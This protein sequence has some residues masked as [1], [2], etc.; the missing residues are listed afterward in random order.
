MTDS[1]AVCLS[2]GH[3]IVTTEVDILL[4]G[5]WILSD[6]ARIVS[7]HGGT[8]ENITPRSEVIREML[9]RYPP[10][11]EAGCLEMAITDSTA[12]CRES[13][14]N[15]PRRVSASS[16]HSVGDA[17]PLIVTG[18]GTYRRDW[19]EPECRACLI[20]WSVFAF[21]AVAIV[22]MAIMGW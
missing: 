18:Q 17:A 11:I 20:I 5:V 3:R 13:G 8:I 1:K 4:G 12:G 21:L 2:N 6:G 9:D 22:V 7:M 16:Y 10:E 19:A 15:V 14:K